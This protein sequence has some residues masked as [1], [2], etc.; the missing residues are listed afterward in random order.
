MAWNASRIFGPAQPGTSESTLYTATGAVVLKEIILANPTANEASI[1]IGINGTTADKLLVPGMSIRAKTIVV[2]ALSTP[3]AA[4][5][6]LKALQGTAS[7][8][9]VTI[10]GEVNS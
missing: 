6:T 3:L 9:T 5:D 7:A 4:T 2:L 1:T 10:S 8:I